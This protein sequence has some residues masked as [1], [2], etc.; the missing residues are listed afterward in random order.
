LNID[1]VI[2]LSVSQVRGIRGATCADENSPGNIIA[3]TRELLSEM[4]RN[5]DVLSEDIASVMFT[6]TDELNA[7]YPAKA[8]RELGLVSVPLMCSREIPVPG[9]VPKCIRVLMLVN[10]SKSQKD[11]VHVYLKEAQRLRPDL[12]K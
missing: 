5:N 7:A 1:E 8:A 3:A 11:L 12:C 4:L 6:V 9:A 10:T 2:D